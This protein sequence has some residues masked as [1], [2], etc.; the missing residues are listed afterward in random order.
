MGWS[1][2]TASPGDWFARRADKTIYEKYFKKTDLQNRIKECMLK[3]I[4]QN[5]LPDNNRYIRKVQ[6]RFR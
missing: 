5:E 4:R 3:D 6:K 2:G 1:L